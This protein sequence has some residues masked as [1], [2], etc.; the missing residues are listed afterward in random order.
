MMSSKSSPVF[1]YT[2]ITISVVVFFGS[3]ALP[4]STLLRLLDDYALRPASFVMASHSLSLITYMFLHFDLQHLASNM[5]VLLSVGRAVET[6]IGT[7]KFGMVFLG[8]GIFS[9]FAHVLFNQGSNISVIG[10]SGAIFGVIAVLLLLMPFTFTSAMLLPLPGVVLG[11]S[12]LAVEIMSLMYGG[13]SYVAH[14]V[15]LYGFVAGS[16][17]SFGIDFNRAMRGLIISVLV[18]VALYYWVYHMNGMGF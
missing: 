17:A 12:M 7:V 14:D 5:F 16:L 8:S 3:F 15:H 4:Q 10:A 6:E 11:L 2:F 13:V 18:V 9:G 1:T